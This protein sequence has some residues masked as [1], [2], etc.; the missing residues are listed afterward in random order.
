MTHISARRQYRSLLYVYYTR[1]PFF[2]PACD[3]ASHILD[4]AGLNSGQ[5]MAEYNTL[6][7]DV[8]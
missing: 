1:F 6:A 2:M 8:Q 3:Y 4:A 7:A 5:T